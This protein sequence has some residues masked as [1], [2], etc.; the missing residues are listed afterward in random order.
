MKRVG[1]LL[2]TYLLPNSILHNKK[3]DDITLEMISKWIALTTLKI[4]KRNSYF[5]YTL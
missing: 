5:I 4:H 3:L 1:T 2:Y